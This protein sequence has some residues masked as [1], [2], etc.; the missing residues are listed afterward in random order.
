[1]EFQP[2][3]QAGGLPVQESYGEIFGS[4]Y[5]GAL[6]AGLQV[7]IMH[8]A[9]FIE[10]G[11]PQAA[12][13]DHPVLFLPG[14]LVSSDE[15][16][17]FLRQYVE[18]GGH[19]VLGIRSLYSDDLARP[20]EAVAP[21]GFAD[22]AGVSYEEFWG[23]RTPMPVRTSKALTAGTGHATR[24]I[25]RLQPS[26]AEVLAW[27]SHPSEGEFSVVTTS[28]CAQ[29]RVTT[30]GTVPDRVLAAGI[31]R[32]ACESS[33]SQEW[34]TDETTY[35]QSGS[36]AAGRRLWFV[37]NWT[38]HMATCR[39]PGVLT[40]AISG[41]NHSPQDDIAVEPWGVRVFVST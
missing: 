21:P 6:D 4:M 20:R 8:P 10:S 5:R 27:A 31:A 25:D 29:G 7:R 15:F 30:V 38:P 1:M 39:Y 32:W 2:P 37:F 14:L 17:S 16:S 40:D 35:V 19:L 28:C 9:Q 22:L 3:F 24:W 26:T 13:R 41:H 33:V 34:V 11:D 23:L 12:A 36:T 18:A